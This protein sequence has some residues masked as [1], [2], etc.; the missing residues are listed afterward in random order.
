MLVVRALTELDLKGVMLSI[1]NFDGVHRGHRE[2]LGRMR[3]LGRRHGA[4]TVVVTFFPPARVV[5]GNATYLSS[6][7]EKLDLLAA[8]EPTAVVMIPFSREY[9]RTDKAV[10]VDQLRRLAPHTIVVGQ[11]FRFGHERAGNLNDLSP[12][13]TRLEAFGLVTHEGEV[14]KSSRV[15]EHLEKGDVERANALLGAPYRATGAVVHGEKRGRDIGYPTANVATGERKA[16][17]PGVFAVTTTTP[18]GTFGG[19]AAVG[20]K[21]MFPDEPPTLE[22]NLF[23]FDGDLYG[24]EVTVFFHAFIR[25]QQRFAGLDELRAALARDEA[26]ARAALDRLAP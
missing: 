15:R 20:S 14:V 19:M 25:E 26:E 5:F 23:G 22:V 9:A 16:L 17:P 12:I 1:G 2:L 3:E 4:P 11:D 6:E 13:A 18:L 7:R 10:F 24:R 8:F 21:P